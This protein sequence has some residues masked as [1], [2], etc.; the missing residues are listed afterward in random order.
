MSKV[1]SQ[2]T[3]AMRTQCALLSLR[4]LYAQGAVYGGT[5]KYRFAVARKYMVCYFTFLN[6][7]VARLNLE[8]PEAIGMQD[9]LHRCRRH[10]LF[11]QDD[12][13]M[14]IQ[15]SMLYASVSYFSEGFDGTNDEVLNDIPR[16]C[17]FVE[18]FIGFKTIMPITRPGV[19]VVL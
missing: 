6:Y 5:R 15:M 7:L 14:M 10:N 8:V 13:R 2:E 11:S 9:I 17:D 18:R 12:E 16:M 4:T 3:H 19:E 1:I